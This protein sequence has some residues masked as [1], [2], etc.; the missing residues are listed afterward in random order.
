M[1]RVSMI[2]ISF[3]EY[4]HEFNSMSKYFIF[5]IGIIVF[6]SCGLNYVP[7]PTMENLVIKRK[8]KV[9][10]Y[11][12]NEY[13]KTGLKYNSLLF[14]ETTVVKPL[15]YKILDSLYTVKYNNQQRG[16][17]EPDLEEKIGNQKQIIQR[18][19]SKVIYIEHHVYAITDSVNSEI[20]FAD[21]S[22]DPALNVTEFAITEQHTIPKGLLEMYSAYL[23][24]E[25]ILNANYLASTSEHN[26]YDFYKKRYNSL[27][28]A[29]REIF[30][31]H[32]LKT[33]QLARK[34]RSIQTEELLK[35][36]AVRYVLNKNYDSAVDKFVS[37]DGLFVENVL[38][39]Y[40]AT[41]DSGGEKYVI[42][43]SPYLEIESTQKAAN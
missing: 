32:T 25:S 18:D 37:I 28:F 15:N 17:F 14:G 3:E 19:S 30:L 11:I 29:E 2:F 31:I 39:G 38:Q 33:F 20:S 26:L 6:S 4:H 7:P 12:A 21:V 41:L 9:E 35:Q 5:I 34:I 36:I 1:Q 23:S 10:S 42:R 43:F 8:L 27:P 13:Q 16:V 22:L 24:E 40:L